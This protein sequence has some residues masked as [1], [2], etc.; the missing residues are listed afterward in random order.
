M[1]RFKG[2]VFW[3]TEILKKLRANN[4]CFVYP[5]LSGTFLYF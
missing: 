1:G 4:K 5:W 3:F 2:W